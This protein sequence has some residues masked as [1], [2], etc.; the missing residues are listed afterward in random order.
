MNDY[1]WI[2]LRH[3]TTPH[4]MRVL[5]FCFLLLCATRAHAQKAYFQQQCDFTI[6]VRLDDQSHILRGFETITY[7]NQSP[8]TLRYIFMHVYPNA[9]KNDK[10]DYTEQQVRQGRTEFYYSSDDDKGFVD[11]LDFRI[12][13]DPVVASNFNNHE[14]VQ[15]LEFNQPLLPGQ[16]ITITTPFRVVLPLIFSRMGHKGQRYQISQWYPKPAVYD[17]KGWHPYPYLDQGEFYSEF[18]NYTVHIEV[19]SLYK[20]AASGVCQTTSENDKIKQWISKPERT[21]KNTSSTATKQLTFQQNQLHDFAWFASKDYKIDYTQLTLPSGKK[22]DCY[23]YYLEKNARLYEKSSAMI[24]KCIEYMSIHV[25][26]YPYSQASIVDGDLEAGGGMEYPMVA[27]IG[28]VQS[29]K[30]LQT[31]IVHEIVHNWFYGILASNERDHPWMDEG[32][33]TFY[34]QQADKSITNNEQTPV[35]INKLEEAFNGRFTFLL[36]ALQHVDQPIDETSAAFTPANYGG[37]VY[38]KAPAMLSY[39]QDYLGHDVFETC[40][41]NYFSTWKFKHPQP[42]DFRNV[43]ETTTRKKLDWFFDDGLRTT[44]NIDFKISNVR[45]FKDKVEVAVR[46]RTN[47]H[48][49]IPVQAC[50]GDSVA[51]IKWIEYPYST[52]AVFEENP[53]VTSYVIDKSASLPEIKISNNRMKTHGLFKYTKPAIRI[54]TGLNLQKDHPLYLLPAVGYNAYDGFMGGIVAHNLRIPNHPF[55]FALAPMYGFNC[56]QLTGTGLLAYSIFP[57]QYLQKITL[58]LTGNS[59]HHQ[60]SKLNI[61]T[62]LFLRHVKLAPSAEMIFKKKEAISTAHNVLNAR[63]VYVANESFSYSKDPVDSLVKPRKEPMEVSHYGEIDFKHS[64]TRTLNPF[65]YDA[66]V[67]GNQEYLKIGVSG[68]ARIDYNMKN[69]GFYVRAYAGKF[70]NLGTSKNPFSLRQRYLTST[71]VGDNDY[72]YDETFI[73]RNEQTGFQSQQITIREGGFKLPTLQYASPIGV[74]DNWLLALNLRSD[75][76]VKLPVKV[77]LFLDIATYADAFKLN[78]SGQK[79]IYDGGVEFHFIQDLVVVYVPL[80]MSKDF[81]DYTKQMYPKNRLLNT[82]SFALNFGQLPMTRTQQALKFLKF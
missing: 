25:G 23:S 42:D 24:A 71:T 4:R 58:S 20:V 44:N 65:S 64:N 26:E 16:Q 48:G 33:C 66:H 5:I 52:P 34:E 2:C 27:V 46:S 18:G 40:M 76:P 43:I 30:E 8:D 3:Q 57:K 49:P 79:A 56:K 75:L 50:I 1:P 78:P 62:P 53:L 13:N 68:N 28:A 60:R 73:A 17:C 69:K 12:N 36:A 32:L 6:D 47:F 59:F 61:A 41:K 51:A 38:R 7:I 10:S 21:E 11:S 67:E 81:K 15:L 45:H 55:Q 31:V 19:P 80:L 72:L 14:D 74:S 37:I 63:Y 35:I 9:F 70:F 77:Q 54:G 39:L 82:I 22:V 29:T